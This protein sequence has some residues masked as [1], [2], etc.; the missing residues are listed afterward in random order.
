L[1]IKS[2]I[3]SVKNDYPFPQI[4]EETSETILNLVSIVKS[5]V[6]QCG[7]ILDIGAGALDKVAVLQKAGY[8]CFACDDF[9]DPWHK[10]E[11][12]IKPLYQYASRNG[13]QVHKQTEEYTIPW[14]TSSFDA[15]IMI[16]V[17][18]HLHQSPRDI[19]N[20]AGK[21]LKEGGLLVIIMPNSVNLRKRISVVTGRSNYTPIRGFFENEGVWRGHVR[22]FTLQETISILEWS[23]FQLVC[24]RTFHGLLH[25]RLSQSYLRLIFVAIC[26]IFPK[27]RDSVLV[28]GIK[29]EGWVIRSSDES[30]LD[31]SLTDSWLA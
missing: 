11:D 18:E 27:F 17:I 24:N 21:Y 22:E 6:P 19:L 10:N 31:R 8:E 28:A 29:P 5:Q 15:V 25:Q 30:A 26:K 1:D 12:H 14:D 13:I 4:F 7:R 23:K 16:N 9:E 2:L 20:F 3:E